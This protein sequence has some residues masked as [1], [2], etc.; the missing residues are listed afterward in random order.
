MQKICLIHTS[1]SS[2][3]EASI[4]AADLMDTRLAACVQISGPGLS[5]YRWQ[6]KVEQTDEYY[7]NIKTSLAC[8]DDV[9]TWLQQNHPYE[10]PEIILTE[11]EATVAYADWLLVQTICE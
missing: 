3:S 6:G 5:V 7:L 8:C 10:L 1:V 11:C 9:V 2:K 4:L